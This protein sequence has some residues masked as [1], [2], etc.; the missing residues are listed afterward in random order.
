MIGNIPQAHDASRYHSAHC[1]RFLFALLQILQISH[2]RWRR[3]HYR[4]VSVLLL[5]L[6]LELPWVLPS[7][8]PL[9]PPLVRPLVPL[10]PCAFPGDRRRYEICHVP[11]AE[12]DEEPFL[13]HPSPYDS[14][15]L[16]ALLLCAPLWLCQDLAQQG[17]EIGDLVSPR[18]GAIAFVTTA[19][20]AVLERLEEVLLAERRRGAG[21]EALLLVCT[22]SPK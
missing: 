6:P 17:P 8:P 13:P 3:R 14:L 18:P 5:V 9:L 22:A 12:R 10:A 4:W 1:E 7:V 2:G 16:L 15:A 11:F 21:Y 19:E 20:V